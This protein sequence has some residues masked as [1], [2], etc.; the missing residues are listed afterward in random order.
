MAPPTSPTR[1]LSPTSTGVSDSPPEYTPTADTNRGESTILETPL[2]PHQTTPNRPLEHRYLNRRRSGGSQ[3]PNDPQ[4]QSGY[5]RQ[6]HSRT[7]FASLSDA[8]QDSTRY[9]NAARIN[10]PITFPPPH[11]PSSPRQPSPPP[12]SSTTS[13]S[14]LPTIPP[15][16]SDFT[17]DFYAVGDFYESSPNDG[18]PFAFAQLST[19]SSYAS[20]ASSPS[21]VLSQFSL[22]NTPAA[23]ETTNGIPDDGRPT[24]KPVLGH[25][26]LRDGKT[27]VYPSGYQCNKCES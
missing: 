22:D 12:A 24:S 4:L 27:L 18:T 7:S 16:D 8:S 5:T 21:A 15:D 14:V 10:R 26:L 19:T 23:S 3:L 11:Q 20:S 1:G 9:V 25:P 2:Q 13:L 6:H 17:R